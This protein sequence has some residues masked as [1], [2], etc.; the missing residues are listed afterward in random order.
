MNYDFSPLA[1][2][3]GASC[4]SL[5]GVEIMCG[6]RYRY[7][8]VGDGRVPDVIWRNEPPSGRKERISP[9]N[10]VRN[11]ERRVEPETNSGTKKK[12]TKNTKQQV[13]RSNRKISNLRFLNS[14]ISKFHNWNELLCVSFFW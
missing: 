8:A 2:C 4:I 1:D 6:S 14:G 9:T 12:K 3:S 11:P 13:I 5:L 10:V 7:R